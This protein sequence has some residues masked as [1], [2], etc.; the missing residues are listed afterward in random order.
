MKFARYE[1]M[2]NNATSPGDREIE[3]GRSLTIR[4]RERG[5]RRDAPRPS[6]AAQ[7]STP[8]FIKECVQHKTSSAVRDDDSSDDLT[9]ENEISRM[10]PER[11]NPLV[12]AYRFNAST[13]PIRGRNRADGV[14]SPIRLSMSLQ[15]L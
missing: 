4:I 3:P 1:I 8:S 12:I 6:A 7:S 2:I 10:K 11:S 15:T 9:L 14:E 13:P 5:G